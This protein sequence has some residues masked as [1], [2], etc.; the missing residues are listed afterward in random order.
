MECCALTSEAQPVECEERVQILNR[1]SAKILLVDDEPWFRVAQARLLR[2]Q[3]Y[4][5]FEAS[6]GK[7][8]ERVFLRD[9]PDLIITDMCMPERDGLDTIRRMGEMDPLVPVIAMSGSGRLMKGDCLA[10]AHYLGVVRT[11]EKP[12]S[13]D[14]LLAAVR[15]AL[16]FL[17]ASLALAE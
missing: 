8:A 4:R 13:M 17:G 2:R 5:V 6:N 7:E 15:S 14:E 1:P 12:F 9:H 10:F 3:G 16:P 11:L